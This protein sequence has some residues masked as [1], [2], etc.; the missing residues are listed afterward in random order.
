LLVEDH[1]QVSPIRYGEQ[2]RANFLVK[3]IC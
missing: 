3:V 1:E 2:P